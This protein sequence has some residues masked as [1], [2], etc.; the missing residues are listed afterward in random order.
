MIGKIV[1][2]HSL[3]KAVSEAFSVRLRG[4]WNSNKLILTDEEGVDGGCSN[5][6][7]PEGSTVRF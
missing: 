1:K 7:D 2:L 4:P 3:A 5:N 6:A